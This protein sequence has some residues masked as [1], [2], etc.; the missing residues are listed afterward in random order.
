[1]NILE[2]QNITKRFPGILANDSINLS[3]RKN[4]VHALLG[5]NGSGKSTLMSILFGMYSMDAGEIYLRGKQE[6]ITNP[7]IAS[8]LGIGMVHQHFQLI[9]AFTIT[10][11][12]VLGVEPKKSLGRINLSTANKKIEQLSERYSLAVD[13][14]ARVQ[15]ISVGMQQRT[16]IL[17]LLYRNAEIMI[18]D[19][20]T[21]VLVPSE[22]EELM[23]IIEILIN[24]GK[25]IILITH[26][27]NEIKRVA[28]RCSVLRKGQYIGTVHVNEV[29]EEALARMMV[30]RPISFDVQKSP[31]KPKKDPILDVKSLLVR[32]SRGLVAVKDCNIRV[33]P[34][35]IVGIAGVEGNGQRE[36]VEALVGDRPVEGGQIQ[37]KGEDITHASIRYRIEAGVGLIPED[38]QRDG[39]VLNFLLYENLAMKRYYQQDYSPH[40]MLDIERMTAFSDTLIKGFDIRCGNAGNTLTRSMSGGNQQKAIIAREIQKSPE[41]LIVVQPTR[42]LDVGAIEYI[43]ARIVEER[44][45]G[46]AILLVSMELSET[47]DLSDI[48]AVMYNGHI[49]DTLPA[50]QVSHTEL[51]LMMIGKN[52][53]HT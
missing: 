34:G 9:D 4:E 14:T 43:H 26:K 20:P 22:I 40:G 5:E 27:L 39:L 16:E 29:D 48:I 12:I 1:M 51:G 45:K 44:D 11:N 19:E 13:P 3:V 15:D 21:A 38:R 25:T 33:H 17:K 24:D 35:E 2:L 41:L 37:F 6:H 30:G 18:L 50:K 28:H 23:Q 7:H 49:I 32:D 8:D 31:H 42:G 53:G 46:R 47:L 36:L 52:N 10:E